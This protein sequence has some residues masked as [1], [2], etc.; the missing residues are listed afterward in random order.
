MKKKSIVKGFGILMMALVCLLSTVS[1]LSAGAAAVSDNNS[2]ASSACSK[3]A[4]EEPTINR[5]PGIYP[6]D[7]DHYLIVYEDGTYRLMHGEDPTHN[8]WTIA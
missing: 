6:I 3:A 7:G 4:S 2:S 5:P 1:V 8:P